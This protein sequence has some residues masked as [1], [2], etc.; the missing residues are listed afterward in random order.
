MNGR[1]HRAAGLACSM[2]VA[3]LA[4]P[5]TLT[6]P[7]LALGSA[8][9]VMAS[10]LPDCDQYEHNVKAALRCIIEFIIFCVLA[11]LLTEK[12]TNWQYAVFIIVAIIAGAVTAHRSATHSVVALAAFSWI[13]SVMIGDNQELTIWFFVAY[14]S[15]LV[16]DILNKRGEMLLWPFSRERFC[17]RLSKSEGNLGKL[18]FRVASIWYVVILGLILLGRYAG[19]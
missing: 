11:Q 15:H 8:A 19:L 17:M 1:T 18:I 4:M 14:A 12:P 10:T 13:F 9:A 2:T 6:L 3:A 7:G 5:D 16:L